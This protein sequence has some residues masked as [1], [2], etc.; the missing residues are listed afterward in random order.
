PPLRRALRVRL[1]HPL[2]ATPNDRTFA[3]GPQGS[4]EQFVLVQSSEPG[5]LKILKL[6]PSVPYVQAEVMEEEAESG[7]ARKGA[8][9]Q[10]RVRISVLSGAPATPFAATLRIVTN[11]ARQPA[12]VLNV[13]GYP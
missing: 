6:E 10:Q 13:S 2:D 3:H 9:S 5:P 4:E 11:N 8:V 12:I 1:P 7:E